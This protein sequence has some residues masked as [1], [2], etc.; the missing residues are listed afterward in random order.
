MGQCDLFAYE[1]LVGKTAVR[2]LS[3][4]L[5]YGSLFEEVVPAIME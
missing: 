1:T 5:F 4:Y 3:I 2:V